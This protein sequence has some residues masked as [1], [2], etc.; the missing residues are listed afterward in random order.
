MDIELRQEYPGGQQIADEPPVFLFDDYLSEQ[1]C[2]HLVDLA[3][4][5]MTRAF[6]SG[7][8]DGVESNGRT[9]G[10]HWIPHRHDETTAGISERI[11]ELVGIPLI[12]AE[13]LQIINYDV[14]Q[15][16]KPHYD[17]W[18]PNTETGD[19]CL[20]RGGQRLV[21][22]LLYLSNVEAGGGTFFPKLDI[23]VMPRPGRMILFHNCYE[24]TTERHPRSLHGGMPPEQGMKWACNL[25]FR[26]SEFQVSRD[27]LKPTSSTTRF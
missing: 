11:A 15:E 10:V 23:E 8:E 19:R 6:V 12:N 17:A 20:A 13:A 21:T 14:G 1:E 16:Y 5:H 18:V 25:W 24:D 7:G 4:P 2:E 9:G 27:P 22:C 26:E 3:R